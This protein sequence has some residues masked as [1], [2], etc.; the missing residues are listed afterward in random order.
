MSNFYVPYS[1]NDCNGIAVWIDWWLDGK[2]SPRSIVST[3]PTDEI[4]EGEYIKWDK[5]TRQ[6]VH[7]VLKPQTVSFDSK[8][9]WSAKFDIREGE[10]T[11]KFDF[12]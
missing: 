2:N 1:N 7:F 8:V 3:G 11:F 5:N 12:L 4:K 10:M 9:T 6:G